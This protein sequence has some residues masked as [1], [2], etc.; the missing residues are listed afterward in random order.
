MFLLQISSVFLGIATRRCQ[1]VRYRCFPTRRFDV[2]VFLGGG[3]RN[4]LT[5]G[6]VKLHE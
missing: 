5:H 3:K 2:G 6:V 4:T 1:M